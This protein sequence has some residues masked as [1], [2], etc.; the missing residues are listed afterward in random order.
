MTVV[1]DLTKLAVSEN[2]DKLAIDVRDASDTIQEVRLNQRE[3]EIR[4]WLSAPDP[5]IN[6]K[7]A[8]EKRHKGTGSWFT[9]SQAFADWKKQPNSFLWLHGISGCG[10]TVLSSTII[11][12]LNSISTPAHVLLYFYFDF[13]DKDKQTLDGMLRSLVSQLYQGWPNTRESLEQLPEV[14][15]RRNQQLSQEPLK[16]V[17][18]TMLSKVNNVSIVLDALD[19]STTRDD[20]LAWMRSVLEAKFCGCRVLVTAR[21][22]VDIESALQRWT[23]LEDRIS[24]QQDDVDGDIRSYV[25]HTVRNSKELE[26]WHKVPEVQEEIEIELVNTAD[27]M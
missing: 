20:L 21:R 7:N 23:R 19:E 17:L 1:H 15:S 12:H 16:N 18:L 11:E 9:G 26:R 8:L 14:P 4:N 25:I 10:K 13:N 2:V 22:H 27:G 24:I 6:Y 5:T 3:R